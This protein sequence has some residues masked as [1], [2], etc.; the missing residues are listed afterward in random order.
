MASSCCLNPQVTTTLLLLQDVHASSSHD[1]RDSYWL[2][3]ARHAATLFASVDWRNARLA[4]GRSGSFLWLF[5]FALE[6]I[7][8]VPLLPWVTLGSPW[9]QLSMTSRMTMSW[10]AST[11]ASV[12]KPKGR[13]I[14]QVMRSIPIDVERG[15]VV[16]FN[17][18]KTRR[19]GRVED[20][21][22]VGCRT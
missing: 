8:S 13:T 11:V 21:A 3:E 19:K 12:S 18:G 14:V 20:P 15:D 5:L 7:G 9:A 16:V 22:P 2:D 17:G 6:A 10:R 1:A 4:N